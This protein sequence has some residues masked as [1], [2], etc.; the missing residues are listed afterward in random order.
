MPK[1]KVRKKA[2]YTPPRDTVSP[3]ARARTKA[4]SPLWYAVLMIGL[5]LVGLIYIVIYYILGQ[6]IGFMVTLGA[7]NFLVGFGLMIAGL[8]MSMRWR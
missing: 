2:T 1:S 8:M 3:G 6:E 7:W 5:M 4:P